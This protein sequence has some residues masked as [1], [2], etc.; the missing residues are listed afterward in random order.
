MQ[1]EVELLIMVTPNF[2]GAMD[3]CEVPAG[4]PGY[5]SNSPLEKELYGKG[6]IEVPPGCAPQGNCP[7]TNCPP[8]QG[9][10]ILYNNASTPNGT[11]GRGMASNGQKP[12]QTPIYSAGTKNQSPIQGGVSAPRPVPV[13]R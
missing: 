8:N 12:T 5:N 6:Y 9:P 1:N 11:A 13:R 10:Q 2:A 4:G 3:A 7:P